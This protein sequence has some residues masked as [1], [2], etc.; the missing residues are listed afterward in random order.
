MYQVEKW[1]IDEV[2][3]VAD[4]GYL[5]ETDVKA[6]VK[7]YKLVDDDGVMKT[8]ARSNGKCVYFATRI[9]EI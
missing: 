5:N 7:G 9:S 1:S 8:Y 6:V 2:K 3:K 4:Y